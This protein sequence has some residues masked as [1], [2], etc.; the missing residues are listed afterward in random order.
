LG[1]HRPATSAGG[2]WSAGPIGAVIPRPPVGP[3]PD[4][5]PIAART[6][7]EH[8]GQG[9]RASSAIPP[10]REDGAPGSRRRPGVGSVP[11][12]AAQ[13]RGELAVQLVEDL[14]VLGHGHPVQRGQFLPGALQGALGDLGARGRPRLLRHGANPS[15]P[16]RRPSTGRSNAYRSWPWNGRGRRPSARTSPRSS[17]PRPVP[18]RPRPAPAPSP[19]RP[20]PRPVLPSQHRPAPRRTSSSPSPHP[21]RRGP[22]PPRP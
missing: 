16:R 11:F 21:P 13:H 8:D 4:R 5:S 12:Q 6:F 22:A 20:S 18:A 1:A 10:D 15:S 17:S 19:A 2:G 3:S 14:R 9:H 7:G